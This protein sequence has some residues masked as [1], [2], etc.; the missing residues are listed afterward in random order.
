MC[1]KYNLFN[2]IKINKRL[3]FVSLILCVLI[4]TG[5]A[6][7]Q[8]NVIINI[9][10]K[11]ELIDLKDKCDKKDGIACSRYAHNIFHDINQKNEYLEK[12]CELKEGYACASLARQ[13]REGTSLTLKDKE[14]AKKYYLDS[15][16]YL[17]KACHTD[18][19]YKINNCQFFYLLTLQA[20]K[21]NL[22]TWQIKMYEVMG[23][24]SIISACNID[25]DKSCWMI[26]TI[27]A[28]DINKKIELD[29]LDY[30]QKSEQINFAI[31]FLKLVDKKSSYYKTSQKTLGELY[32]E[33][34]LYSLALESFENA[35]NTE[36]PQGCLNA[37]KMYFIGEHVKYNF[38][39]ARDLFGKACDLGKKEGCLLF[40]EIIST[41]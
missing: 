41:Q 6:K 3:L 34:E 5:S 18:N 33:L 26:G 32:L 12:A 7:E 31:Q 16:D 37:G 19:E 38:N 1:I 39:K 22:E 28:I 15:L 24:E 40:K 27:N 11:Q 23:K 25:H 10:D 13:Y 35:C 2:K 14:K 36:E 29:D 30:N 9:K 8:T 20:N 4:Q 21:Y 17:S